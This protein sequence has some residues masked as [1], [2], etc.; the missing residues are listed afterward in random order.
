MSC[1]IGSECDLVDTLVGAAGAAV[2]WCT[3]L[4]TGAFVGVIGSTPIDLLSDVLL[5]DVLSDV[6]FGAM[7]FGSAGLVIVVSL[8]MVGVVPLGVIAK[9]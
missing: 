1:V 4:L 2:D 5:S 3:C 7:A 9:V 8:G 6:C